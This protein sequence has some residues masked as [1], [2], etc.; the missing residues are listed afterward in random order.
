MCL[1]LRLPSCN[2]RCFDYRDVDAVDFDADFDSDYD[3]R[4]D[5][6]H[7]YASFLYRLD[8]VRQIDSHNRGPGCV[9]DNWNN[10]RI[11]RSPRNAANTTFIVYIPHSFIFEWSYICILYMNGLDVIWLFEF[12]SDSLV[13]VIHFHLYQSLLMLVIISQ[14]I[15]FYVNKYFWILNWERIIPPTLKSQFINDFFLYLS[16]TLNKQFVYKQYFTSGELRSGSWKLKAMER[17]SN[18]HNSQ[19][20]YY[21]VYSIHTVRLI[22]SLSDD[23]TVYFDMIPALLI[24]YCILISLGKFRT[25]PNCGEFS[26]MVNAQ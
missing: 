7:R 15:I 11:I 16:V 25:E 8:V 1:V 12:L 13:H 21:S 23:A 18:G 22:L 2:L 19:S 20:S 6:H 3:G 14:S 9:A 24:G 17:L 26:C 10:D 4:D 5:D